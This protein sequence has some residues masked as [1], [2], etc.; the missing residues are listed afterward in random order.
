MKEL[1]NPAWIMQRRGEHTDLLFQGIE[2]STN[3]GRMVRQRSQQ[4][5]LPDASQFKVL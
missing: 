1:S 2:Q 3:S 5:W 4:D